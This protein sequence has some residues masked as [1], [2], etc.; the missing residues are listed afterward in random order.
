MRIKLII[1]PLLRL[2]PFK[3]ETDKRKSGYC[4]RT[5]KRRDET[6]GEYEEK[7]TVGEKG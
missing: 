6:R 5:R 4:T 2:N 7:G 3:R 1:V